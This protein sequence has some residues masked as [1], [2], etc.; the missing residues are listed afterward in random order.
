VQLASLIN[1]NR[2]I[3]VDGLAELSGNSVVTGTTKEGQ[4]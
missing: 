2:S 1:R 4:I 3:I